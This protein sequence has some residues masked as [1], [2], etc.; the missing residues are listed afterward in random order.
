MGTCETETGSKCLKVVGVAAGGAHEGLQV[1]DF[2]LELTGRVRLKRAPPFV[3]PA[4]DDG[5]LQRLLGVGS[6]D[7][8]GSQLSTGIRERFAR[9]SRTTA[10]D[11]ERPA[12]A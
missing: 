4:A 11:C 1:A 8:P 3:E 7:K 10:N 9:R 5:G 2:L 6:G 12:N